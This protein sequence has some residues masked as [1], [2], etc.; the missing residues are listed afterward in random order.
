MN[1]VCHVKSKKFQNKNDEEF[2]MLQE[3]QDKD[4]IIRRQII[5]FELFFSEYQCEIVF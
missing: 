1:F 2:Y 3:F 4:K 5:K